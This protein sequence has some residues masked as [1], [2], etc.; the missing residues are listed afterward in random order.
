MYI[1]IIISF[2]LKQCFSNLNTWQ[3]HLE[4]LYKHRFWGLLL[5]ISHWVGLGW[6]PDLHLHYAN[7]DDANDDDSTKT[8]ITT[9]LEF[10]WVQKNR[11]IFYRK[12]KKIFS[13]KRF[14]NVG[15]IARSI[16]KS[17]EQDK[18][19]IFTP[20]LNIIVLINLYQNRYPS[21]F[22]IEK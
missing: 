5:K 13:W 11:S 9:E 4:G 10:P 8:L 14:L 19:I 18:D 22:W 6:A 21:Q 20:I 15:W 16:S 12:K 1:T 3:N 7:D 2:K 17:S